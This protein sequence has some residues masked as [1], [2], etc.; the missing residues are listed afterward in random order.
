[1]P[2]VE[3]RQARDIQQLYTWMSEIRV[4]VAIIRE[5]QQELSNR[6]SPGIPVW[7]VVALALPQTLVALFLLLIA[8]EVLVR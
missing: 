3:S 8:V 5:Q 1:M 4:A 6:P 2:D 7:V